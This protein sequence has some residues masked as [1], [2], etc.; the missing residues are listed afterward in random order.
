MKFL[1]YQR[2]FGMKRSP[3]GGRTPTS[4]KTLLKTFNTRK[5]AEH[6]MK[7]MEHR[8]DKTIGFYI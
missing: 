4:N 2:T 6:Y 3:R 5:E 1:V 8:K 7:S